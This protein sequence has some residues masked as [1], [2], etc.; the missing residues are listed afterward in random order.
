[1][2]FLTKLKA[3]IMGVHY[4]WADDRQIIMNVYVEHPWT[5]AEYNATMDNLLPIIRDSNRPCATAVDCSQMGALPRD[6]NFL[7][8]LM[9]VE[10]NMPPNVFASVIVAAP[11]GVMVFMNMLMKL[12]PRAKVLALFTGTMAEAHQKIYERYQ[13]LYPNLGEVSATGKKG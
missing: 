4:E 13:Q 2:K 1:M 3:N 10:K 8:I 5:W 7:S 11:Y 6:G 9:N 12:R